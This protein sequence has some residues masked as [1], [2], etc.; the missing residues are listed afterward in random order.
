MG[1]LA[2]GGA[3]DEAGAHRL[4]ALW[5]RDGTSVGTVARALVGSCV[6]AGVGPAGL[7]ASRGV[8][9]FLDKNRHYTG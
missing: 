2:R 1:R 5:L 6:P 3:T 7:A 4:M 8:S 9:I